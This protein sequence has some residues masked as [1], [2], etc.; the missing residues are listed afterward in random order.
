MKSFLIICIFSLLLFSGVKDLEKD[1]YTNKHLSNIANSIKP[2]LPMMVDDETRLDS[3]LSF[4]KNLKYVYT[5]VNA[6]QSDFNQRSL[7]NALKPKVQNSVCTNE[8]TM[9]FPRNNVVLTFTYYS[10]KGKFISE[11]SVKPDKRYE[12]YNELIFLDF[13]FSFGM[14]L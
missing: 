2:Y 5:M 11:F 13:N 10:K 9:V 1:V 14:Q 8:T 3:I 6:N 12:K 7:E 4:E